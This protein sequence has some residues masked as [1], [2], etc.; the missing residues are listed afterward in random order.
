MVYGM[1]TVNPYT[2]IPLYDERMHNKSLRE[3]ILNDNK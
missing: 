3:E 1:R 2:I